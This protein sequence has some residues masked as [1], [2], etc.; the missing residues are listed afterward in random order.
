MLSFPSGRLGTS[1]LRCGTMRATGGEKL[2]AL[3]RITAGSRLGLPRQKVGAAEYES[4]G[5][6]WGAAP[7]RPRLKYL[8]I[9]ETGPA[10]LT[11]PL[12]GPRVIKA[13]LSGQRRQQSAGHGIRQW[14]MGVTTSNVSRQCNLQAWC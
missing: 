2:T 8:P 10:G 13:T 5:P 11:K 4:S 7:I 3:K 9:L 6:G 12:T 14:Y 1:C